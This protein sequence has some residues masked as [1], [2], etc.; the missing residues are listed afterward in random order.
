MQQKAFTLLNKGMNRDLSIS[1]A[2][3][4]S[5]YENHNIRIIA[6][7]HDTLLSVTNE[8]GNR[9]IV[10]GDHA[11]IEGELIGWNVLNE[12]IILFTHKDGSEKPDYIYRIDYEDSGV[13]KMRRGSTFYNEPLYNGNLNFDTEHPIESVVYFETENI[14]KIYWVDGKNVLRFMNFAADDAEVARWDDTYFDSNRVADP[15]VTVRIEK[16]NS[17]NTRANGVIQYLLTYYN[18]HGQETGYIWISDLIYLS[19]VNSGG[20]ADGTNNNKVTLE[21]ENLDTTFSNYRVYAIFRSSLNST[22]VAYM[23]A[24]GEIEKTKVKMVN[25]KSPTFSGTLEHVVLFALVDGDQEDQEAHHHED[26]VLD[27]SDQG[28]NDQDDEDH[29]DT[30]GDGD[31]GTGSSSGGGGNGGTSPTNPTPADNPLIPSDSDESTGKYH[32]IR[33][34]INGYAKVV[35]DGAHLIAEDASRLLYLGSQPVIP[36]TL[37]HK[38]QT[39]FL[40]DLQSIGK[41]DYGVISEHIAA[42]RDKNTGI[43]YDQYLRFRL[44]DSSNSDIADI[45][46]HADT[47]AYEYDNQLAYTSSQIL[48]FKGGEKYRFALTFRREDGTSTEAFWIG[49]AVNS[50]YPVIDVNDNVIKRIVAEVTLPQDVITDMTNAKF[51][52]AQLMIAEAS[53][54]DRSVKAQGIINPTMFNVWDRFNGRLYGMSSWIS[55]PRNSGFAWKH[56]EPVHSS[57]SSSGEIDCNYWISDDPTPYYRVDSS[58][59]LVDAFDGTSAP[60]RFMVI[61]QITKTSR[62][63]FD[64]TGWVVMG[65]G[66]ET[67]LNSF[68]FEDFRYSYNGEGVTIT[69]DHTSKTY[70]TTIENSARDGYTWLKTDL[71]AAYEWLLN[72]LVD[73]STFESWCKYVKDNCK[74]GKRRL[75]KKN[76]S[77]S[78]YDTWE[79]VANAG[80]SNKWELADVASKGRGNDYTPSYYR[81]HLMFVDENLLTFNSPELTYEAVSFDNASNY[82]LRIVGV[83][84]V[85]ETFGDYVVDATPGKLPGENLIREKFVGNTDGIISWPVWKEC[86]LWK[87]DEENRYVPTEEINRTNDDYRWGEGHVNYWLHM[88]NHSGKIPGFTDKDNS[89]YSRL[90]TKT[91]ANFRYSYNTIYTALGTKN[92]DYDLDSLRVFNYTSSQY[93]Q[94]K[95]GKDFFYYDANIN[96]S[97]MPPGEHKYPVVYSVDSP[98]TT[99]H[100]DSNLAY[101]Y[102]NTPVDMNYLSSPHAVLSLHTDDK[103]SSGYYKQTILPA[104]G[105]SEAV[106]IPSGSICPWWGKS[107]TSY[108]NAEYR[109][110]QNVLRIDSDSR[111]GL[112]SPEDK[113]LFIGEIYY[114]YDSDSSADTRYG[115]VEDN[116]FVVAGP[117]YTIEYLSSG[118]KPMYA[119]Q[120]DTYI[121]RWDCLKTKPYSTTDATNNVIDIASVILETHIN[122]DG[123]TDNR[124]DIGR[125]ASM[126]TSKHGSLN[127]VYSQKNN[128]FAQRDLDEDFDQDVYG[129]NIT[130]TLEKHDSAEIDEWSHITLANTLKLD[131]DK[132]NCRALRRFQNSIIAFQD[133]G[134]AEILFNSRTQLTTTDGVPVEL[135]NSGKVDGKRYIT[136]K[137]GCTN[138]WSIVEGKSALYFID[139][140]NKAFCAFDGNSI[141]DISTKLNFGVWFRDINKMDPWTPKRFE[142]VVSFYDRTYSDV[143][144]VKDSNDSMPCLVYNENLGVFTS[145]FDYDRVPMMVNVRDKFLSYKRNLLWRQNEGFYCNFFG[146]Q[147]DFWV[148]Y[149]VTPDPYGDK[150]WTNIDYRADF[151]SVLDSMSTDIVQEGKLI[152]G[153]LGSLGSISNTSLIPVGEAETSD[154]LPIEPVAGRDLYI[155]NE[156]FTGYK[157]W[158]EYQTT[159]YVSVNKNTAQVDPVR[160][161]F[162]IWRIAI[163]RA[164]RHDTN[165]RGLDRI[166]NPWVN[167]EFRKKMT[168]NRYLMQLHDIVVKYFE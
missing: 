49:D 117:Q 133:K 92:A 56:F 18:K 90:I 46:Y 68:N 37:A 67:A 10:I 132:G 72:E 71:E 8:R 114:D 33:M 44:S 102:L 42:M 85:T 40:G 105:D 61:Y 109:V 87:T 148:N 43:I 9:S 93:T 50:L 53:Y 111:A 16:D 124:R 141:G 7:D 134:I 123:R 157:V 20:A 69:I 166:R 163:P 47:G 142:N 153:D 4:S 81:K 128:Y 35:D 94:V 103:I 88:W 74:T 137:Y 32:K 138:K 17:G 125:I 21:F 144:L 146:E 83:A 108:T 70:T 60:A 36:G 100:I 58:D 131:G 77:S 1:K 25:M 3:E 115:S 107:N 12:H 118:N 59:N 113:Y 154:G 86:D 29:D 52:T 110:K 22:P 112:L 84:R 140:I 91:F 135:A 38:D 168:D 156:T 147:K 165:K 130:W 126:D 159:G 78:G 2:G 162:R 152:N 62:G 5:A 76:T 75:F 28:H 143:Y 139:N 119:N 11:V 106:N 65:E 164:I 48:S 31:T 26:E 167:I 97:L 34:V 151:Y 30:F 104:I 63:R 23:V 82:K 136:N 122:V 161:K 55:R 14:Q 27:P 6:R 99:S 39:L 89:D 101:L 57:T 66:T 116:R 129:T 79:D 19:P 149:R 15:G 24:E 80:S 98:A 95:V 45:P 145:F 121:Q 64:V 160:K 54:A 120:G 150:I 127:P 13:Y 96:Q 73:F 51:V 155:E 158:N 41:S